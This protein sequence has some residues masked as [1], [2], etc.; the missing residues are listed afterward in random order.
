MGGKLYHY[1]FFHDA[2]FS[3]AILRSIK[4]FEALSLM[5]IRLLFR[6]GKRESNLDQN[7][8]NK[9]RQAAL[10]LVKHRLLVSECLPGRES[11]DRLGACRIEYR[12]GKERRPIRTR[13]VKMRGDHHASGFDGNLEA[14]DNTLTG[15]HML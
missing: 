10:L 6:E 7:P 15:R 3:R 14:G 1:P 9:V 4:E 13:S 2:L 5:D 12:R 11:Y 8:P